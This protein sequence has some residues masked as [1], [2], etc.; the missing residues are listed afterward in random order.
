M[1]NL[2]TICIIAIYLSGCAPTSVEETPPP[3]NIIYI[4][5][6][7][8][9][10]GDLSCYNPESKIKTPYIDEFATQGMRF[11][12]AHSPSA[13]CTPTR[14]GILT[15]RYCWRSRLPR[16]VLHGYSPTLIL[17]DRTTIAKLLKR[18]GYQT[19]VVGKWHLGINW[20]TLSGNRPGESQAS[21]LTP[22]LHPDSVDV[23]QSVTGGP[24]AAGFDYSFIL[25]ASLDMEPYCYF[26]NN[27]VVTPA[28]DHTEG[29]DLDTGYE[30]AFWREGKIAP[31]FDFEQVMPNFIQKSIDFVRKEAKTETPF[32]LY[33]PLASPH[34]PWVPTDDYKGKSG[35]GTYGDFV[36]M[37]DDYVGKLLTELDNLEISENTLVVFTSD[38]GPYWR[39]GSIEKYDHR[40]A[41]MLK[42]MKADIYEGGH[43]VPFIVRWP[44]KIEPNSQSY[45]LMGLTDFVA[46]AAAI[47]GD[48]LAEN[49]GEDSFNMLPALRGVPQERP[50]RDHLICQSSG[51][52][53]AI[54]QGSWK[55]VPALGSGGFSQPRT[56]TP[57]EGEAIGQLYNLEDDISETKNLYLEEPERVAEMEA[58]LRSVRDVS[59][60]RGHLE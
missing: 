57:K 41:Y 45:E 36:Q 14:Y 3:P 29:N 58:R 18:N 4:L 27:Q 51:G 47:V 48:T 22:D 55:F 42:G 39:P 7:D 5:A 60:S 25:P 38:N 10:Y 52:Y 2:L 20:A 56:I 59:M 28:T 15:G 50:I 31:D 16:G 26:E 9:G 32:F 43:R 40:A 46:T 8:L 23:N 53:F 54:R 35:A 34:T 12:D 30:E 13:V 33:L 6:D 37:V 1:R 19:A 24:I 44:G 11:T 17:N 21:P 49:E